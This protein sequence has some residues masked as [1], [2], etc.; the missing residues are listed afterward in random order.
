[1]IPEMLQAVAAGISGTPQPFEGASFAPLCTETDRWL[2]WTRPAAQLRNRIR[3]WGSQGALSSIEGQT[4]IVR[5]A[6]TAASSA[7]VQPGTVVDHTDNTF[8][9][10]TGE[11]ALLIIDFKRDE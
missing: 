10:Q 6:R 8:L 11:G 9:V 3:G 4:Y 1:M 5:R 7:T 2:D